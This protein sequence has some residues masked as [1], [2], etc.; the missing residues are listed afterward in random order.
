MKRITEKKFGKKSVFTVDTIIAGD[1]IDTYE[2]NVQKD[3][4]KVKNKEY[5]LVYDS[6]Y[7]L[8]SDAYDYLNHND[9]RLSEN[10]KVH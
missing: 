2:V 5:Y 10:T 9:K 4:V 8:I 7:N 1:V 3:V 6:E